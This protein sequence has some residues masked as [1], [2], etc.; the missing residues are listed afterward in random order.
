MS[1]ALATKNV[2]TVLV[3]VALVLG[4]AFAFATPA[5]ADTLSD[6]QAQV[7]AL[8]AQIA[9]LQG[10]SSSSSSSGAGCY[11]FTQNLKAG[12]TGGEVMW[13]QKFLNSHGF[14][15]SASGAGS[16]GNETSTF[17]PA[18][19]AAVIKF[20]NAN[21]ADILTP[22][23]L[24]AGT[25]NWFAST[26]A[27]AN[28]MCAGAPGTPSTVPA[29]GGNL[30]VGAAAQPA[31]SLA[32]KGTSRVPFTVFTLTNNS[33]AAVT[34]NSVTVQRT[35]LGQDAAFAGVILVDE[36]GNQLGN[37]RT[38]N[39]NHQVNAGD[40]F[41]INP[42]Q[43]KT[44]SV[45]GNMAS[46]LADYAGQVVSLSVVGIN[47]NG[48]VS[49]VLPIS[50]ASHTL[51]NTL[52]IGTATIA[53][54]SSDLNA[55]QSSESI[56][57]TAEMAAAVR[58]TAGSGED[59]WVKSIR[60]NQSGS[61]G[62]A[63]ITNVITY[64]DGTAYPTSVSA[65][66]KY[67]SVTFPGNGIMIGKGL[68]K[69]ILVKF[70]IVNGPSR[71]VQFDIYKNTDLYLVGGT[72]GYGIVA[73]PNSTAS[74]G[75]GSQFTT[76]SPWF[77]GS[78]FTI[79]AGT[80]TSLSRANEVTAQNISLV[81]P[82]QPLGG[83]AMDVKGEG[84]QVQNMNFYLAT[85]SSAGSGLL[86]SVRMVDEN[87]VVVAGP[88]DA[89]YFSS[90]LQKVAFS[91]AVTFPTGRHVYSL[92]GML[93]STLANGGTI[94]AQTTPSTDWIGGSITGVITGNSI[95]VSTL[96][97]TV[98]GNLMTIRS[99]SIV[100]SV[101]STPAAQTMVSGVSG[102]TVAAINLDGT[103]SGEDVRFTSMKLY[104]T[105]TAMAADPTNCFVYDGATRL[106]D[107]A[108]NPTTGA[109]TDYTFTLNNPLTVVKG[110]VKLVT[111]KCDLS[112]AITSGSFSFGLQNSS[113]LTFTGTGVSSSQTITP[114]S[115]TGGSQTGNTMTIAGSGSLSVAADPSAPAYSVAAVGS[116]GSTGVTLNALRFS[117]TNED[118]KLDR[119]AL[120]MSG[121]SATSSPGNITQ[122]TIWDGVTQVGTAIF[123]GSRFAT[124]TLTSNVIIPANGSKTL[125]IKGDLAGISLNGAGT[126]GA[127]LQVDYDG[128]DSTGTRAIGQSS[129]STINTSSTSDTAVAGV[130][131]YRSV[132][133][134]TYAATAGALVNGTQQLVTVTIA[135]DS[136]G[137]VQMYQLRFATSTTAAVL[138]AHTFTGPSGSV[139][140]VTN[141]ATYIQVVFDNGSNVGDRTISAGT[142]KSYQLGATVGGLTGSTAG[143]ASFSLMADAAHPA[144]GPTL[145]NTASNV[146]SDSDFVWSPMS[147]TSAVT[148]VYADFTNGYGLGGCFT[149][150][151][152]GQ[153]CVAV[154][155]A[156]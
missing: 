57:K 6:L 42:G 109:P 91:D 14:Q 41:V 90:S 35:G 28:A 38:F 106:N 81:S 146:A 125:T 102:A 149:T 80:V 10:G 40:A 3:A 145:M 32:P 66:G 85:S 130:R 69:E 147:T 25:G 83:F 140:T 143:V 51:N 117:G 11:T 134:I 16:P 82:N 75:A 20:Q 98:S 17:G 55:D 133:I 105:D 45:M 59:L 100:G 61:A 92:Q 97:T 155:K 99:G 44:I 65:D 67:Y 89:T 50:G 156:Q 120:Q 47:T 9:A 95:S 36:M 24:T 137:D 152:V 33:G 121:T 107:T 88:V 122:V 53:V 39:S 1:K 64:V 72:Y 34:V 136:K 151:G 22:V 43:T 23:G 103:Q 74:A 93:P 73:T 119:I 110:T 118:M 70:D 21:A 4:F 144:V 123:A 128:S 150:S 63:D 7:Q 37:A 148:S 30:S 108:V 5:K 49:G 139:G 46:S 29:T 52:T 31:N 114:T 19:K 131:T 8:L 27:K 77:S 138:T 132:P 94:Q 78:V 79:S 142:S 112:S 113:G 48:T 58:V 60:W 26:R 129:G 18:T 96:S 86:T 154:S 104:Y 127:L 15:V 56:G 13:V 54:G 116:T 126:A 141:T 62:A 76:G 2:A 153:N 84:I 87:G 71:T 12:S 115:S 124:S 101:A 68:S 135:A 111:L